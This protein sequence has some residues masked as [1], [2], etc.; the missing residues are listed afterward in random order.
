MISSPLSIF[1]SNVPPFL[2]PGVDPF[3][4][5]HQCC[6]G[7]GGFTN[8]FPN[9]AIAFIQKK[10]DAILEETQADGIV[11]S[12]ITCLMHLDNVQKHTT[13]AKKFLSVGVTSLCTET[14]RIIP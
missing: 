8:N 13:P 7:A 12:C 6:G 3:S 1:L 11:T 4:R 2:L 14:T 9:E 10:F 5:E